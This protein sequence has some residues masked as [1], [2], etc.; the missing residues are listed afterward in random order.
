MEPSSLPN[1]EGELVSPSTQDPLRQKW[2]LSPEF[3]TQVETGHRKQI[4]EDST[5]CGEGRREQG[6][7]AGIGREN[8][9]SGGIGE[10]VRSWQAEMLRADVRR[11]E[12]MA[13]LNWEVESSQQLES[14]I[15]F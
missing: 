1:R 11:E 12:A 9:L 15:L 5:V 6:W 2:L 10:W 14:H 7:P 13:G 3:L 4:A 8:S